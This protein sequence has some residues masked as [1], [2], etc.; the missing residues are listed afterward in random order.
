MQVT[1]CSLDVPVPMHMTLPINELQRRAEE[2]EFS[3]LLDQA[4]LCPCLWCALVMKRRIALGLL[5][6]PLV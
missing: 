6:T 1:K 3:H 5:H 2:L 4:H